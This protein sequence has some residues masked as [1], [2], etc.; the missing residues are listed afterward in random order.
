MTIQQDSRFGQILVFYV[1][2]IHVSFDKTIAVKPFFRYS[3]RVLLKMRGQPTVASARSLSSHGVSKS[4][5]NHGR[6]QE[7]RQPMDASKSFVNARTWAR[8]TS[9]HGC[10]QELCQPRTWARVSYVNPWTPARAPSTHGRL[11]KFRQFDVRTVASKSMVCT[12]NI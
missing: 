11:Q 12:V 8:A 7:L 5:V 2:H 9:T 1:K 4:S 6:E 3:S 10:Q